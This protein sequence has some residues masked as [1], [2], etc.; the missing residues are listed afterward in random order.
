[1][2]CGVI[3]STLANTRIL[4]EARSSDRGLVGLG[5]IAEED[6]Q[7]DGVTDD[8]SGLHWQ[9]PRCQLANGHD[10]RAGRRHTRVIVLKTIGEVPAGARY[11][12]R[13]AL[14]SMKGRSLRGG[15][16]S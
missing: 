1:M 7:G 3:G 5:S 11:T 10:D 4:D 13:V 2:L 8:A 15:G 12:K 9:Q 6:R 16:L 14:V